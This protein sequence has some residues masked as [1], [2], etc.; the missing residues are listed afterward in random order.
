MMPEIKK[1]VQ[2]SGKEEGR[3]IGESKTGYDGEL[4]AEKA[5]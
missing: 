1:K 5:G 4:L 2:D 3:I